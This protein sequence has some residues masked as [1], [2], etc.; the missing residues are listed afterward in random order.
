MSFARREG[1]GVERGKSVS[2]ACLWVDVVW[3][4]QESQRKS[5]WGW[6]VG[7]EVVEDLSGWSRVLERCGQG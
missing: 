1:G 3:F 4:S 2:V 6:G 5:V 7:Q